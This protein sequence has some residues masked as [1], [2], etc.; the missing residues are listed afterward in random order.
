[1]TNYNALSPTQK[2][3][4]QKAANT[5][6]LVAAMTILPGGKSHEKWD[7][8]YSQILHFAKEQSTHIDF[9]DSDVYEQTIT[10]LSEAINSYAFK[11]GAN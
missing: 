7:T 8:L 1:M 11:I 4:I 3:D 2:A 9:S 10:K 5:V 6:A